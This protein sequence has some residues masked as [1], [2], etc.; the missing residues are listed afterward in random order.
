MGLCL[1]FVE[2][3]GVGDVVDG[4]DVACGLYDGEYGWVE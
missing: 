1:E 2:V 4:W 3:L